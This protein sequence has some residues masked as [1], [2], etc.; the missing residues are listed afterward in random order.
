M[1]IIAPVAAAMVLASPAQAQQS[2]SVAPRAMQA[3]APALELYRRGAVR[4]RVETVGAA[5]A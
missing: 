2:P 1:K 4:R 5:S 3:V